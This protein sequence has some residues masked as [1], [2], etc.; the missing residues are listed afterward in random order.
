[1]KYHLIIL[2]AFVVV[3]SCQENHGC[4]VGCKCPDFPSFFT[5][6]ENEK[7]F[8]EKHD[9]CSF[10]LTCPE[11]TNAALFNKFSESEFPTPSENWNGMFYI[12]GSPYKGPLVPPYDI[13]S[14]FG[15]ICENGSWYA[16]KYPVGIQYNVDRLNFA[17]LG[18][19]EEYAGM[20]SRVHQATCWYWPF[21]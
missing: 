7:F 10:N 11:G 12:I 14:H 16:T 19:A 20:K 13:L 1:M 6:E 18:S 17:A 21:D 8:Y 4:E 5:L 15:L 2:F 9:G 3:A